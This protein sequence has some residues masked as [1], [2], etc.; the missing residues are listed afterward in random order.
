MS[1]YSP[2]EFVWHCVGV[3]AA[4]LLIC[5]LIWFTVADKPVRGYYLSEGYRA[6]FVIGVDIDNWEATACNCSLKLALLI[7]LKLHN[8]NNNQ[9]NF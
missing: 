2:F 9:A 8:R 7:L 4:L 5:L 6:G 1:R 3:L